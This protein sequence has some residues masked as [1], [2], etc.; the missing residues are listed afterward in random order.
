NTRSEATRSEAFN[1]SPRSGAAARETKRQQQRLRQ[2]LVREWSE[3]PYAM[4]RLT[5]ERRPWDSNRSYSRE[6][7]RHDF[8]L[9]PSLEDDQLRWSAPGICDTPNLTTDQLAEKLLA[10]LVAFYT[11]GLS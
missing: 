11:T 2:L 1:A 6:D 10:K 3:L 4:M 8:A 7:R 9:H 5:A